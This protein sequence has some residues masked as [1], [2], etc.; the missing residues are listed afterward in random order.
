MKD[1][2]DNTAK[3]KKEVK[4]PPD[5]PPDIVHEITDLKQKVTKLEDEAEDFIKSQK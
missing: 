5:L 2:T 1:D 3:D 4:L